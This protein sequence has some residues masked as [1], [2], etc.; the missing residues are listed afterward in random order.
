MF[1]WTSRYAT[2]ESFWQLSSYDDNKVNCGLHDNDYT[3]LSQ[4]MEMNN[5]VTSDDF[6]KIAIN[7][8]GINIGSHLAQTTKNRRFV[9]CFGISS[10]G[11]RRLWKFLITKNLLPRC[12]HP[13]HLLW[14]LFFLK[15]YKSENVICA[16]FGCNEK[17]L[18]NWVWSII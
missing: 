7:Q 9:A 10:R 15:Q 4:I 18:H 1:S 14:M 11:C 12:G 17:P 13:K 5:I 8:L 6:E 3:R 16:Q 2:L